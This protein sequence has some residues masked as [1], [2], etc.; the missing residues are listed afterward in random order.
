MQ[1]SWSMISG[2]WQFAVKV[3]TATPDR[4]LNGQ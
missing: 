4:Q 2:Q 1:G 3:P